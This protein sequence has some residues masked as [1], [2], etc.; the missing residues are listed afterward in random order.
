MQQT[1]TTAWVVYEIPARGK[2]EAARAVC[3]QSEWDELDR[4]KPGYFTLIQS[5]INNEGEAERL[6]RGRSGEVPARKSTRKAMD[7]SRP[8][9]APSPQAEAAQ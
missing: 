4:G 5:G 3:D 6:A 7:W 2:L 1:R 8:A 9:A